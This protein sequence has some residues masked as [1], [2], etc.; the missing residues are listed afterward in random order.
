MIWMK[1]SLPSSYADIL[2]KTERYEMEEVRII[3]FFSNYIISDEKTV[4]L[5]LR[6]LKLIEEPFGVLM[7]KR[8]VAAMFPTLH[9]YRS[10]LKSIMAG[11]HAWDIARNMTESFEIEGVVDIGE[12]TNFIRCIT[13]N[14][15]SRY[16]NSLKEDT[17]TVTKQSTNKRKIRAEYMFY[18]L[19]PEDMRH[20][21][22]QPYDYQEGELSSSYR[23]ERL[24]MTDLAIKW[25]HGSMDVPE[26]SNLMN[27]YFYFF[28]CRHERP[29]SQDSFVKQ[30]DVLYVDKVKNRIAELKNLP[31]YQGIGRML[32]AS[33][34]DLDSYVA[35][36]LSLK[37]K[38]E[39]N[40]RC[41]Q[42]IGH[43]DPCF[44]NALYNKSTQTL[45]FIDP[46]GALE[47]K[48][49]WTDPYYDVAKLSHSV[50]GR[51]DFF[52]NALY[53]I[54]LSEDLSYSLSIPFD[55]RKFIE[56]FKEIVTVNGFDYRLVRLYE[57]SLFLSMLPLHIDNPHKVFGFILN[58]RDIL[59]E[60]EQNV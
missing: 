38:L 8:S 37:S 17:Y 32:S 25:V 41:T 22:V 52:N 36:Y 23:M 10:F 57:A 51:Y 21:F 42:V 20:W 6:K 4:S 54:S 2:K 58:A 5:S 33:G 46:K 15:D 34:E 11:G 40:T 47:E 18:Q 49:L 55:N 59:K 44:A 56:V 50:C 60:L 13:G 16:F 45:K 1:V 3:H 9:G 48:E 30:R 28:S 39:K 31:Q 7:K 24:Y 14:F 27:R 43:G 12:T 53:E 19:I 29:C 26:F 35:R